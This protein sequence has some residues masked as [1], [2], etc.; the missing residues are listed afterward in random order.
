MRSIRIAIA[1]V[2]MTSLTSVFSADEKIETKLLLQQAKQAFVAGNRDEAIKIATLMIAEDPENPNCYF[3]RARCYELEGKSE[4]A[5]EDYSRMIE[6]APFA[7]EARYH[8]GTQYFLLGR[9]PESVVDYNVLADS[10]P[11]RAAQYWQRGIALYYDGKYDDGRKQFELHRTVNPR[12]VE[13]TLWHF[14]CVAR[15]KNVE[16]ARKTMIPVSGDARIP[17]SQLLDLYA[18]TT[19]PEK[20]LQAAED[21][22]SEKRLILLQQL[23]AHLYIALLYDVQGER[24]LCRKHLQRAVDLNLKNEY[25]WE[26]A[27]V[28]LQL[29]DSGQLK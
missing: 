21:P 6:M 8:R 4:L 27:R 29:L 14:L 7:P 24:E 9:I 16:E 20:V 15:L 18:G 3:L 10:Q 2:L 11:D 26:V 25:M 5:V 12:D 23:Y 22:K 17:M 1:V 13:N 28:H 19:T